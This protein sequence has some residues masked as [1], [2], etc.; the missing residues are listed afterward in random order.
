MASPNFELSRSWNW[1]SSLGVFR[2]TEKGFALS[3]HH[4]MD[5]LLFRSQFGSSQFGSSQALSSPHRFRRMD[6]LAPKKARIELFGR[7]RRWHR[8]REWGFIYSELH[9]YDVYFD[10]FDTAIASSLKEGDYVV[11][12]VVTD[13]DGQPTAR[14]VRKIDRHEV[15]LRH[16]NEANAQAKRFLKSSTASEK[17]HP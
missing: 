13:T 10:G 14:K 12:E 3:I 7:L 2:A 9:N 5:S 4:H 8:N 16:K 11:F 1:P 6:A 15:L 17:R